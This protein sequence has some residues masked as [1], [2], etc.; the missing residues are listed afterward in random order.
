VVPDRR[1]APARWAI[2]RRS[3]T[4]E[5]EAAALFEAVLAAHGDALGTFARRLVGAGPEAED[6]VQE[7]LLRAWSHPA[8]I[9]GSKGSAR[10]WLFSV[11]RNLA[12]DHWRR[13]SKLR[14][15]ADPAFARA[16]GLGERESH[17]LSSEVAER[18]VEEALVAV[19]LECLSEEHRQVL[20]HAI[21]L[22]QPVACIAEDLGIPPGTVKSRVHYGL[23]ALRLVLE[24]M[25]YLL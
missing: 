13:H 5:T 18:V 8:A 23:K 2:R 20:F 10:A 7:T 19:A 21:W 3:G 16:A 14:R 24:E 22:D 6:L 12:I 17:P 11:A 15:E 9:D 4:A 25:G 1:H